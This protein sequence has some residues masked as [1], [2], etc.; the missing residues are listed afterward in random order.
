[1]KLTLDKFLRATFILLILVASCKAEQWLDVIKR[2]L[3][4]LRKPLPQ[5]ASYYITKFDSHGFYYSL[6][7]HMQELDKKLDE[8][9]FVEELKNKKYVR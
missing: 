5:A 1:M 7:F 8:N 3:D 6:N 4:H 2:E 9:K